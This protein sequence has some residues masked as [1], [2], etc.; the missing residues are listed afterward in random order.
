[1]FFFKF[2]IETANTVTLME[3]VTLACVLSI[4]PYTSSACTLVNMEIITNIPFARVHGALNFTPLG[5]MSSQNK[6][7]I[8]TK[9]QQTILM[10]FYITVCLGCKINY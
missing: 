2:H 7:E 6:D 8:F 1:M 5:R 10:I 3:V 9:C 4:L